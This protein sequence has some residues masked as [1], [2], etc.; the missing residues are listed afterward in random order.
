MC[1]D[2]ITDVSLDSVN[3]RAS[4]TPNRRWHCQ[5]PDKTGR[6]L[7]GAL[8][9]HSP[10]CQSRDPRPPKHGAIYE[11]PVE[12]FLRIFQLLAPLRTRDNAY[13]LLNLTHVCQLWRIA[14]INTP[15]M[16]ATI[17]VTGDDRRS[18]VET[19]LE[20]SRPVSLEV[21]V[22]V[23][24]KEQRYLLCTCGEDGW[25]RLIPNEIN[26]CEWHFAF[27][28]LAQT[29][30]LERICMLSIRFV[31]VYAPHGEPIQ[32]VVGFLICLLSNSPVSNGGTEQRDTLIAS[33]SRIST[34]LCAP[35][36]SADPGIVNLRK[37]IT[38]PPSPSGM[39]PRTPMQRPFAHSC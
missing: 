14:L 2:G 15:R 9:Q 21:M 31:Y 16:W 12:I 37:S 18:F 19:W 28:S 34:L 10:Q 8:V 32:L 26:P 33:L 30:H 4:L 5:Q 27:E 11:V 17:L 22:T 1:N 38:L 20:R 29:K 6:S 23:S 25:W 36:P 35:C 7:T 39:T 13:T 3:T 24:A